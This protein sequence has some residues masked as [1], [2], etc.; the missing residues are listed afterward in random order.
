[1]PAWKKTTHP[2]AEVK[3]RDPLLCLNCGHHQSQHDF[4]VGCLVEGGTKELEDDIGKKIYA[5]S[6]E[7]FKETVHAK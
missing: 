1:M 6:C 4:N 7:Q 3:V 2:V 5:C